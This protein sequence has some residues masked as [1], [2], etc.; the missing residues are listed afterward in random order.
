MR[1]ENDKY[2]NTVEA[3]K[4][5]GVSPM[6]V[7]RWI[8]KGIIHAEVKKT[9]FRKFYLIPEEEIERLKKELE[10]SS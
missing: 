1:R 9:V 5:L 2:Y 7:L 6:T 10:S 4:K 8:Q 3:A